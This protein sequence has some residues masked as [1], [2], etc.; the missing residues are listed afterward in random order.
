MSV[1]VISEVKLG[2]VILNRYNWSRRVFAPDII[3]VLDDNICRFVNF[4]IK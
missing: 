4:N 2:Y 3:A 1:C